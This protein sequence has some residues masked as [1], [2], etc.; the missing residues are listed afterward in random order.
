MHDLG[1]GVRRGLIRHGEA[2]DLAPGV[3]QPGDL[4]DGRAR[5]RSVRVAHRL[6]RDRRAAADG[7]GADMDLFCLGSVHKHSCISER[8]KT[9]ESPRRKIPSRLR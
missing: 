4:L 2:D 9:H 6:H 8:P 5:V 1:Q 7:D 3:M